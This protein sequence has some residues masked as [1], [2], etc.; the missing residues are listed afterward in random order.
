MVQNE[1]RPKLFIEYM[2][3]G[4]RIRYGPYWTISP[5]GCGAV[6]GQNWFA[7][8]VQTAQRQFVRIIVPTRYHTFLSE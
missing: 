1:R 8:S 5:D 3:N 7:Y 2:K 6:I 4:E